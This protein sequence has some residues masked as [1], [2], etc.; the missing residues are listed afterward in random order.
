MTKVF[1]RPLGLGLCILALPFALRGASTPEPQQSSQ[2]NPPA[3]S[4]GQAQQATPQ[5]DSKD[6]KSGKAEGPQN[7]KND[8]IFGVV[9]NYTTVEHPTVITPISVKE[10]FK[11]GAE[12]SFDPYEF[13]LAGAVA[14]IT[15]ARNEDPTWG[16]GFNGYGKRYAAAFGDTATGSFMTTGLFPSMLHED[17]RY[18]RK[19]SGGFWH[20]SGY[21]FKRLFVIRTDSGNDQFNFSEFG[22]N[23]AAAGLSLTYHSRQE[24]NLSSFWNGLGTQ[25]TIDAI[26]NQC[27]EF[28]PDIRHKVFKK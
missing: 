10:K 16:Q 12:D 25:V 17:P 11:L 13:P 3:T 21:A 22:G 28:W 6:N 23:A 14:G 24:R 2:T 20:R 9:P 15:Q 8:R 7:P 4:S 19:E 26:A 27:K 18:F 5:K 1:L